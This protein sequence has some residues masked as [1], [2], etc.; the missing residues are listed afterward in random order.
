MF[1]GYG[2]ELYYSK[3]KFVITGN[4]VAVVDSGL[5]FTPVPNAERTF[6]YT[7]EAIENEIANLTAVINDVSNNTRLRN[8]AQNQIDVWNQVLQLNE[9]NKN[10][11]GNELIG[12]LNFSAGTSQNHSRAA[13]TLCVVA[14]GAA[15]P[16]P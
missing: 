6:V 12:Q 14:S 5:V 2:R 15:P 1:I 3:Y 13:G 7:A 4:C 8:E 9:A 11:P 16:H 10:N